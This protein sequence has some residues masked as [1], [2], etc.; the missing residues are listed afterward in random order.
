MNSKLAL[1]K[2]LQN[3]QTFWTRLTKKEKKREKIQITRVKN[4]REDI[5]TDH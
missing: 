3:W 5:A 1:G 4:E 2:D